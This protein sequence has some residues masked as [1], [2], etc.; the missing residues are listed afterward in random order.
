[1]DELYR[2]QVDY[3]VVLMARFGAAG[4]WWQ[5][6]Q[7]SGHVGVPA[8]GSTTSFDVADLHAREVQCTG[9]GFAASC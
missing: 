7:N 5:G 6:G 3:E 9:L 1:M 2:C 8:T 4:V